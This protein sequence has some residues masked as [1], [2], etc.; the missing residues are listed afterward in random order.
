MGDRFNI[1]RRAPTKVGP[2]SDNWRRSLA[3]AQRSGGCEWFTA[4]NRC[5]SVNAQESSPQ[6]SM[7]R[8][9][10]HKP[11][12]RVTNEEIAARAYMKHLGHPASSDC[13]VKDWLE[14]ERELILENLL[15]ST[16][17]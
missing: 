3:I 11:L 10:T 7:W 9:A 13:A 14:A 15:A 5:G 6:L 1:G 4:C 16:L 2:S 17:L 8:Q 12:V